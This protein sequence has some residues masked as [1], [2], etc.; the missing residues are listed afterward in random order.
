M[1]VSAWA[2]YNSAKEYIGD[3]TIDLD[4]EQMFVSL[5]TSA[6]NAATATLTTYAS[7]TGEVTS[8]N[9]YTAGGK[10]TVSMTWAV[11]A[12]A[13]EFR[14]DCTA[15]IWCAA[16]GAISAVKYA[17]LRT[18]AGKIVCQSTLTSL[19]FAITT[20]NNATITPSANGVFELN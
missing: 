11:G 17:V 20:G 14:L 9:G 4:G 6:S 15:L 13:S 12:S 19:Q 18:S 1:A 8:A 16:G 2:F 10:S 5:H 7:V 3:N